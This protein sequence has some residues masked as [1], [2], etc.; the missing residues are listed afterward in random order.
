LLQWEAVHAMC[1]CGSEQQM[2][3]QGAEAVI[4]HQADP[5]MGNQWHGDT[6]DMKPWH[7][8]PGFTALVCPTTRSMCHGCWVTED[9]TTAGHHGI[10]LL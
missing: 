6:K 5:Q 10:V 9:V 1:F 8:E 2:W 7:D 4:R 3:D